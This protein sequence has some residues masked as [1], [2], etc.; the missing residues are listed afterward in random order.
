MPDKIY[1]AILWDGQKQIK[2]HLHLV[3]HHLQFKM[4]DFADTDLDLDISYSDIE[5]VE[6]H[7][8]YDMTTQGLEIITKNQRKNIF[9][10]D[11][12]NDV[13]S[14]IDKRTRKPT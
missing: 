2:G 9:I 8:L 3:E 7:Q 11:D 13:K 1:K 4:I 14:S 5:K 10:L 6:Y 12:P